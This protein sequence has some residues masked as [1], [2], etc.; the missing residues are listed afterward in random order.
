MLSARTKLQ[1]GGTGVAIAVAFS[2]VIRL[3]GTDLLTNPKF[4]IGM[5]TVGAAITTGTFLFTA[6][7]IQR[8]SSGSLFTVTAILNAGALL[9]D[10]LLFAYYPQIYGVSTEARANAGGLLMYGVA[11]LQLYAALS[12]KC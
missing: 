10:G 3:W 5:H 6:K 11:V 8:V 1:L 7:A 9:G 2:Q 4:I 12:E